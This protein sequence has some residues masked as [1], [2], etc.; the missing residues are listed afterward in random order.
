MG[1]MPPVIEPAASDRSG[2][3]P[4]AIVALAVVVGAL[5]RLIPVVTTDFPINDGGLFASMIED[6]VRHGP[7]PPQT[8][9]YNHA[10]IPFAYPPL[11]LYLGAGLV[12]VGVPTLD[13]LRFVPVTVAILI[14]PAWYLLARELVDARLAAVTTLLFALFPR[15]F[16]WLIAGGGLTR[17]VGLLFAILGLRYALIHLRE[18]RRRDGLTGGLMLGLACIAH[19]EAAV[20]GASS[21]L[22]FGW[23]RRAPL[24]RL[25]GIGFVAAAAASPWMIYVLIAHGPGPL[26]SAGSSRTGNY[27]PLLLHLLKFDLT[28][29]VYTAIGTTLGGIG[30][31]VACTSGR[32]W[33]LAW[34]VLIFVVT[35][36]AG[37]TFMMMPLSVAAAITANEVLVPRLSVAWRPRIVAGAVVILFLNAA[38]SN[39]SPESGLMSVPSSVRQAMRWTVD[40]FGQDTV[41]LVATGAPWPADAVGEWFPYITGAVSAA[42]VQGREWTTDW[43]GALD[44][45]R[46]FEECARRSYGCVA[47]LAARSWPSAR[48]LFIPTVTVPWVRPADIQELIYSARRDGDVVYDESGALI[49]RLT[50]QSDGSG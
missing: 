23:V 39:H 37:A 18:G 25:I 16:E 5:V 31:F 20:F 19:P 11:A 34:L 48:L 21:L 6:I 24:T 33:V 27:L 30:L 50:N 17:A 12:S 41:V 15:S 26:L 32:C 29:E 4:A 42:T 1:T 43:T 47:D 45:H 8:I 13:V 36:G 40:Q 9:S 28:E 49:V 44:R 7:L 3:P 10:D 46:E 38:W 35:S 2:I 14:I 22:L